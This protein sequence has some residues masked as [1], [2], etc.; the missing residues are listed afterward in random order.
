MVFLYLIYDRFLRIWGC[1]MA[2][3]YNSLKFIK[4]AIKHIGRGTYYGKRKDKFGI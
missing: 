1:D 3:K 2:E 4:E